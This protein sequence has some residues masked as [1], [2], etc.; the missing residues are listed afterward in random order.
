MLW[1]QPLAKPS[2]RSELESWN[3]M[4]EDERWISFDPQVGKENL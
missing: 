1:E 4:Q 2:I 3:G